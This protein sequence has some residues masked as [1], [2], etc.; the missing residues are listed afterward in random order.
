MLRCPL[1]GSDPEK[2]FEAKG[3]PIYD[4]LS[5]RHR[6][7]DIAA[8]AD[9]LEKVYDDSYFC[10]G[11]AGYPDY[12]ADAELLTERGRYYS[13]ILASFTEPGRILDVGAAAGYILKGMTESGWSGLGLEPNRSMAEFGKQQ[14]GLEMNSGTLPDISCVETFDALS[15]IQ[16]AAHFS[17]PAAN[18]G[19]AFELLKPNGILLVETWDRGSFTARVF[20]KHWHEYSP[21]SVLQWYSFDGLTE[22]LRGVG[23]EIVGRGRP[24]KKIS[25]AHARD[26]KSVV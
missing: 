12:L 22:F 25:G 10:G 2:N 19:K 4:C 16:V 1:C 3:F 24:S 5:C 20:G 7:A 11:G 26:R 6:F 8:S 23:F 9:H 21:P 14:L 15:M 13:K 18:F 17:D